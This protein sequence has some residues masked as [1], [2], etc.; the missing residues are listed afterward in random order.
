VASFLKT[1]PSVF[2]APLIGFLNTKNQLGIFL[3]SWTVLII[4]SIFVYLLLSKRDKKISI[5]VEIGEEL[6]VPEL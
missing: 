2:L 3:L 6:R 5:D 1:I 4:I